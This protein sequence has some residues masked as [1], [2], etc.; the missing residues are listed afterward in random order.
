MGNERLEL[1]FVQ[2]CFLMRSH[3][4]Y[5]LKEKSTHVDYVVYEAQMENLKIK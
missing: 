2:I 1:A 3:F 5:V 4:P